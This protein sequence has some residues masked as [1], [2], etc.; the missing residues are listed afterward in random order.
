MVALRVIEDLPYGPHVAAL[1]EYQHRRTTRVGA[2]AELVVFFKVVFKHL[3]PGCRV[4]AVTV[5]EG[6]EFVVMP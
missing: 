3:L 1:V 2:S 5:L 4:P 6:P